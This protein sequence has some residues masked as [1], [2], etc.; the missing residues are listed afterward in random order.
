MRKSEVIEEIS[1][2]LFTLS[3]NEQ[4]EIIQTALAHHIIILIDIFS[5]K[6]LSFNEAKDNIKNVTQ[7]IIIP[8]IKIFI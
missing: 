4:S 2:S 7:K 1:Q 5:E 8:V 6:K 3:L